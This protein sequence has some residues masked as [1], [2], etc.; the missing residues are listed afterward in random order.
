MI[1]I[2]VVAH[3]EMADGLLDAARMIVGPQEGLLG[4]GLQEGD[5][6]EGLLERVEQAVA[7][8]DTGDGALLLVDL[9][10]A[11]PF[12]ACARLA[13]AR[14]NAEVVSGVNLPMLLEV[15]TQRE[16]LGLPEAVAIAREAGTSGIRTLSEVLGGNPD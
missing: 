15:V 14:K 6:V 11:S 12:N 16:G 10:G 5:A 4:L 7:Q 13:M 8:V 1:G 2:V 3:G 9:F